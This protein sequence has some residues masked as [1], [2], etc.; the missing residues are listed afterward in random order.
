MGNWAA[1]SPL[2]RWAI[3]FVLLAGSFW[4]RWQGLGVFPRPGQTADEYSSYW[5]GLALWD[6]QRPI[7]WST[8]PSYA[9][10]GAKLGNVHWQN[11]TFEI[12]RPALDHPPLFNLLAGGAARLMG[13]SPL[14]LQTESGRPVQLWE[15]PLAKARLVSLALFCVTFLLLYDLSKRTLGFG[16][17]LPHASFLRVHLARGRA[18]SPAGER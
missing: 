9:R 13:T 18:Q 6:G 11:R 5:I 4:L 2:K 16:G 1:D 15:I 14:A 10:Q 17:A 8:L 3:V 7:A 12:V